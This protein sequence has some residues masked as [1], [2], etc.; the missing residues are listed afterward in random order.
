MKE[1]KYRAIRNLSV[2]WCT[3]ALH[4]SDKSDRN[5]KIL[6]EAVL[7]LVIILTVNI[8]VKELTFYNYVYIFII[9]HTITWLLIG[10][11]WVYMLDSFKFV[12]NQGITKILDFMVFVKKL[13][14][15]SHSID[16]VYVYGSMCRGEFHIRSDIDLRI[17]RRT[18]SMVGLVSLFLALLLRAYSF[19]IRMPLDLQVVDDHKFLLKMRSDEFPIIVYQRGNF[20]IPNPGI[21]LN[22]VLK[23]PEI[24]LLK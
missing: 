1:G 20:T 10:N 22:D 17:I 24:V 2:G 19:F 9:T 4:S 21:K 18:D 6:T 3:Q 11:F 23:D 8:Y 14:E 16:A 13:A 12:K 7:L 15:A 5:F